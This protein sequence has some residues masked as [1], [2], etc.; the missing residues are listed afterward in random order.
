LITVDQVKQTIHK[1]PDF[2]VQAAKHSGVNDDSE[3]T[4]R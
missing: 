3:R 1:I 2:A 4:I